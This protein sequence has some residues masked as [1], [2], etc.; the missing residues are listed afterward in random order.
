M[1]GNAD[2]AAATNLIYAK[3]REGFD[4]PVIDF[5][6]P[7]FAVA[8]DPQS[9]EA[10]HRAFLQWHRTRQRLPKFLMRLFL[11]R[12]AKRSRLVRAL[13]QSETGY[14]DSIST[15]VLKLGVQN[16][17]VGFDGPI[18]RKIASSPHVALVRLRMQQVA[19]LLAEALVP[20]LSADTSAP[21]HLIN[22]A[23]G[24]ALDSI[25]IVLMLNRD[26]P[27]LL[28][29]AIVIDVLDAQSD[30]PFFGANALTALKQAG[31]PLSGLDITFQ[32]RSYDWNA[33]DALARLVA[34]LQSR[35]AVVAASSEGGL[36]EYG[37]DDAIVASVRFVAGSVTGGSELRKQMIAET[38]FKLYPRGAV[39]LRPLAEQAGYDIV[40]SRVNVISDQVL[41]RLR[42]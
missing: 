33:T 1:T 28:R 16:L 25:N 21:L 37:S 15:Y 41:L 39:G 10:Q 42:G 11:K 23:G 19:G 2:G 36:F 34:Q 12:A 27:D 31:G 17:P 4:L 6:N 24:P 38:K 18:D 29:R 5:T 9:L 13:F 14:L 20:A 35:R 32:H 30:G 40:E 22:I 7:R 8:D 26:R 3:T